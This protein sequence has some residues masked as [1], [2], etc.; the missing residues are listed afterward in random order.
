MKRGR[1]DFELFQPRTESEE[2]VLTR[3]LW[4]TFPLKPSSLASPQILC[5][6]VFIQ[7]RVHDNI[8]CKS[9]SVLKHH[10]N[11]RQVSALFHTANMNLIIKYRP[12]F[13]NFLVASHIL[14]LITVH[15]GKNG[16]FKVHSASR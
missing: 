11:C 14:Q 9:F 16:L 3:T 1:L 13:V 5:F 6:H 2:I 10:L 4:Q 7:L 12:Q 8:N 15:L